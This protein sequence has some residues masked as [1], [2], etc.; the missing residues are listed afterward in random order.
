MAGLTRWYRKSASMVLHKDVVME[1][2]A[3]MGLHHATLSA[4]ARGALERHSTSRSVAEV[5]AFASRPQMQ[6]NTYLTCSRCSLSIKR[7]SAHF[8][9][10][11]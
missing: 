4:S 9:F 2:R 5:E 6:R 11:D 7:V 10:L 8:W 3:A 1:L